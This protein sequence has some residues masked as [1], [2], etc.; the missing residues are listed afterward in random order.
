[1]ITVKCTREGLI[2]Q[3]TASGYKIDTIVPYVALPTHRALG[4]FVKVFLNWKAGIAERSTYA[5][6]LDV[7][8]WN[9]HDDAYVFQTLTM[10]NLEYMQNTTGI[11]NP[12]AEVRPLS[13]SGVDV[14]G[15]G[16]TNGAGIDLGE[17]VWKALGL[18]PS[19][20]SATV[21]W[22]FL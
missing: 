19:G 16:K 13:E 18:P 2:G 9:E 15:N 10:N 7:G 12:Q 21:S 1:M 4:R 3:L 11:A 8:P 20:G 6:V 17:A 14:S 5:V 22:E